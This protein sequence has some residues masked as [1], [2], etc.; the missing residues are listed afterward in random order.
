VLRNH[1]LPAMQKCIN[2]DGGLGWTCVIDR[3]S[4][5]CWYF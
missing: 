3:W 1:I 4:C 2:D 5:T